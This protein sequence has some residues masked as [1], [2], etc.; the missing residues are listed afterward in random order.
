MSAVPSPAR[1]DPLHEIFAAL[2]GHASSNV[3]V[4]AR[5]LSRNHFMLDL[6]SADHTFEG[7]ETFIQPDRDG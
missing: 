2:A 3:N 4:V 7:A 6:S 1:D 5:Y